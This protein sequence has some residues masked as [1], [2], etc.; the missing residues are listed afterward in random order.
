MATPAAAVPGSPVPGPRSP[1]H[2]IY[3]G[4]FDPVHLGHVGIA[5]SARDALQVPVRLMP[6]ADPP[7]RDI[8][9]AN[10][11]QRAQMLELAVAGETGLLVDRRELQRAGRSYTVDTLE[12]IRGEIGPA[13]PLAIL[14]GADSFAGLEAWHRW[15][16]LFTLAHLI[17]AARA[18]S[19]LGAGASQALAAQTTG[20]WVQEPEDLLH[21]PAGRLLQLPHTRQPESA[22]E[23]RARIAAGGAWETLL[24]P[25]V[26]RFIRM[27]RLYGA[28]PL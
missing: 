15:T 5:R 28:G 11:E 16:E 2:L 25:P 14:M 23:V 27:N 22:T 9:G 7:H 26:A 20:R 3:G 6:A 1:L 24:P 19:P 13:Q 12:Q 18:G 4:T 17:V 8:P 10:A 21:A